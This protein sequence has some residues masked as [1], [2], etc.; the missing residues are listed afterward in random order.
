MSYGILVKDTPTFPESSTSIA[1]DGYIGNYYAILNKDKIINDNFL[2]IIHP[3]DSYAYFNVSTNLNEWLNQQQRIYVGVMYSYFIFNKDSD[4]L[5]NYFAWHYSHDV[6]SKDN[7]LTFLQ[8][9]RFYLYCLYQRKMK[10]RAD[11]YLKT[12]KEINWSIARS[13]KDF[14]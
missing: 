14:L 3:K 11:Y 2:P 8:Q 7:K 1:D 6:K 4:F 9:I 10:K 13:T 5:R 12:N